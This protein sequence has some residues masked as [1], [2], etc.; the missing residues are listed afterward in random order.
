[1]NFSRFRVV[2]AAQIALA[3]A[4]FSLTACQ[5]TPEKRIARQA[6][7]F[8]AMSPE[9]QEKIRAGRVE[10]GFT[11]LQ[12]QL[13]KGSP[14][15]VSRRTTAQGEEEIW[16]YE[17]ARSGLGF[18]LGVGGGSGGLGGGVGVSTGGRAAEP[19]L[20]VSF[21]GGTVTAVEDFAR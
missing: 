12:V 3:A 11:P 21:T 15:R 20:R 19:A 8:A 2:H 9:T 7:A 16:T 6:E 10:V 5:S 14:D 4:L 13:A 1:M 18:G 17:R